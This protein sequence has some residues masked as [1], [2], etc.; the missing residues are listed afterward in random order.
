MRTIDSLE[1]VGTDKAYSK[2]LNGFVRKALKGLNYASA[3]TAESLGAYLKSPVFGERPRL[4]RISQARGSNQGTRLIRT[5]IVLP[6]RSHCYSCVSCFTRRVCDRSAITAPNSDV[7]PNASLAAE[8]M[9]AEALQMV[10]DGD[11]RV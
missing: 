4:L 9:L 1:F 10:E 3:C 6:G 11:T 5:K 2:K 7:H 8:G